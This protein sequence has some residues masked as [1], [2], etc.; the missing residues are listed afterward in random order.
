M[1]MRMRFDEEGTLPPGALLVMLCCHGI[2]CSELHLS[3]EDLRRGIA[4]IERWL[5]LVA[6]IIYW[7]LDTKLGN[8][9]ATQ[10][11]VSKPLIE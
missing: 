1:R 8:T 9:S 3:E 4:R 11:H 10:L 6:I 5:N 7:R 2:R